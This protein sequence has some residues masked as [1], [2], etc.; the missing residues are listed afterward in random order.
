[1]MLSSRKDTKVKKIKQYLTS[2]SFTSSHVFYQKK[3]QQQQGAVKSLSLSLNSNP[4]S[5][6]GPICRLSLDLSNSNG[7]YYLPWKTAV[8]TENEASVYNDV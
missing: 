4:Y 1:M 7:N 8:R 5:V 2:L 3:T 6:P